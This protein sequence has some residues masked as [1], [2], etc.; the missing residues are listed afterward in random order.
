MVVGCSCFHCRNCCP[1]GDI[2][3]RHKEVVRPRCSTSFVLGNPLRYRFDEAHYPRIHFLVERQSPGEE[4]ECDPIDSKEPGIAIPHRLQQF[5]YRNRAAPH[6]A[7]RRHSDRLPWLPVRLSF[8]SPDRPR[9]TP[10]APAGLLLQGHARS[11]KAL[12]PGVSVSSVRRH[13]RLL[14]NSRRPR[15]LRFAAAGAAVP[16]HF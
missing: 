1:G 4:S 16:A 12:A 13:S 5:C 8:E 11:I 14:S 2:V 15:H 9:P 10:K 6:S 3:P 7:T